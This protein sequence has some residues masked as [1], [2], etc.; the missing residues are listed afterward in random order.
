MSVVRPQF[1]FSIVC[2]P[3]MFNETEH[4][5][6][7]L[8]NENLID[9]TDCDGLRFIQR[10]DAGHGKAWFFDRSGK[11]QKVFTRTEPEVATV[12]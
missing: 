8:V 1:S 3:D 7:Q 10:P 5:L 4:L 9:P 2:T 11:L 12:H 6:Y